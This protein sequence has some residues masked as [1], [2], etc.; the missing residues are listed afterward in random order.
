MVLV[1][2]QTR[3]NMLLVGRLGMSP[4]FSFEIKCPVLVIF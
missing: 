1:R 2:F 3:S 4:E